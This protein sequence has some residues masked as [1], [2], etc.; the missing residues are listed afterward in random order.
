MFYGAQIIRTIVVQ[1]QFMELV[2]MRTTTSSSRLVYGDSS[3]ADNNFKI[4]DVSGRVI[5]INGE[6]RKIASLSF[7]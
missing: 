7:P 4:L 6:V 5:Q 1:G 3:H 2:P